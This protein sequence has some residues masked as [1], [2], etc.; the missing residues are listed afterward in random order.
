VQNRGP[1]SVGIAEL[2]FHRTPGGAD[3]LGDPIR[4][5][6]CGV[7]GSQRLQCGFKHVL[8][9]GI[10]APVRA[11]QLNGRVGHPADHTAGPDHTFNVSQNLR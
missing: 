2:V 1:Q 11:L 3:Q 6:R 9:G 7:A 4:R 10:A 8:A 5:D